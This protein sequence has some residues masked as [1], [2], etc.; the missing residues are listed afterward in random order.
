MKVDLAVPTGGTDLNRLADHLGVT[1]KAMK[2]LSAEL[3]LGY[4]PMQAEKIR[5]PFRS[6]QLSRDDIGRPS[7][8]EA[9]A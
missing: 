3:V 5:V 1:R 9:A 4:I 7:E 8:L 2:D 6:R